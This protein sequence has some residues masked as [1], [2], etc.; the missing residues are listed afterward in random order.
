MYRVFTSP[1]SLGKWVRG[2]VYRVVSLCISSSL[3]VLFF[4]FRGSYSTALLRLDMA[5][6]GT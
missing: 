4:L 5:P 2:G 1:L 3:S 6:Y